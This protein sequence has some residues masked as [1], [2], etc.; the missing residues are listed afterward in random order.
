MP[1]LVTGDIVPDGQDDALDW[2]H[3]GLY[4]FEFAD[5]VGTNLIADDSGQEGE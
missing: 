5:R 4:R 1:R 2:V 3:S